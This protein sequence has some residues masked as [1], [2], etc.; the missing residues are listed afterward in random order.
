VL[1][2]FELELGLAPVEPDFEEAS[3]IFATERRFIPRRPRLGLD[4][5]HSLFPIAVAA[6]VALRFV[7]HA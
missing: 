3:N 4:H 1:G 5:L 7:E 6:G 2:G